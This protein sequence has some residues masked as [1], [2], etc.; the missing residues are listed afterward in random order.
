MSAD[1]YAAA[2]ETARRAR[3]LQAEPDGTP[4]PLPPALARAVAEIE[5]SGEAKVLAVDFDQVGLYLSVT[6]DGSLTM[7]GKA[8]RESVLRVLQHVIDGLESGQI[9]P[10]DGDD[11][12]EIEVP[13][14]GPEIRARLAEQVALRDEF[15]SGHERD[16]T[17]AWVDAL[18][19]V[20][21]RRE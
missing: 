14:S 19:W 10:P 3:G 11:R 7:G 15:T 8:D 6:L 17:A 4:R 5:G 9:G 2:R 13:R 20:L 16:V 21:G 1:P 18:E 12:P